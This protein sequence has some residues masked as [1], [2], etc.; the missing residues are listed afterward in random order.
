MA[1]RHF[2][3]STFGLAAAREFPEGLEGRPDV[4]SGPVLFGLGPSA[5]GF[6]IAAAAIMGDAETARQLLKASV[7]VGMPALRRGELEYTIMPPVGQAVILFGK[8]LLLDSPN[9]KSEVRSKSP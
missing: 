8:T 4:D 6:A 5:S 2:L 3:R 7:L 1:K 9:G